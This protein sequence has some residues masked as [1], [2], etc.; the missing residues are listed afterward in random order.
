MG[1]DINRNYGYIWGN[2]ESPCGESFPGPHPFSEPEARAMRNLLMKNQD[3]I[4]FVYNFHSYG[5]MW[6]WPY[7]GELKNELAES[8][9]LAQQIFNEIWEEAK[10]PSS[11]LHGNAIQTVG[12][13]AN[14][15][16]NDYIMK[17]FD[18]PSVTPE[19]GNDNF[20][21]GDF[22]IAYPFVVREVL[23]DN[24]PW[25]THTFKKLSGEVDISNL[26]INGII[27]TF[28]MVNTGL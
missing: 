7:N 20:L 3:T 14:G 24:E 10:F 18:I 2:N 15:E 5:P 9:P 13:T 28:D 11:T 12:Y 17:A 21:S 4:K 23:R 1:V 25:V 8:N 16:A 26:N 27:F 19:L 22:F 6:V